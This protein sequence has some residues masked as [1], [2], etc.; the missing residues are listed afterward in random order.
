MLNKCSYN[1]IFEQYTHI[2]SVV[3]VYTV[4]GI[5]LA[6]ANICVLL[7]LELSF[8]KYISGLTFFLAKTWAIQSGYRQ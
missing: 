4:L 8:T 1:F 6:R 3:P 2:Y 5:G 7:K